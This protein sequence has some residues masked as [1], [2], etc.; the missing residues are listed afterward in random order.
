MPF[1]DYVQREIME[2]LQMQSSTLL[3]DGLARQAWAAGHT[4]TAAGAM[5]VIPHYPYNR[6]D[7]PSSTLHS[8]R[9]STSPVRPT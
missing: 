8:R 4:R 1:E 7:A 5:T 9:R 2:P 3:N 6:A